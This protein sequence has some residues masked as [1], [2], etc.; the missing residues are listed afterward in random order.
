MKHYKNSPQRCVFIAKPTEGYA[1]KDRDDTAGHFF[2]TGV[3]A[4]G[5]DNVDPDCFL[6]QETKCFG[7]VACSLTRKAAPKEANYFP[8]SLPFQMNDTNVDPMRVYF[9]SI[10]QD[11]GQPPLRGIWKEDLTTIWASKLSNERYAPKEVLAADC[12][13]SSLPSFVH[14]LHYF[15]SVDVNA[16][17]VQ[18]NPEG[19]AIVQRQSEGNPACHT[20]HIFN[21]NHFHWNLSETNK[22]L[23][24]QNITSHIMGAAT[25][26]ASAFFIGLVS[27]VI[28]CTMIIAYHLVSAKAEISNPPCRSWSSAE[29]IAGAKGRPGTMRK[30][31]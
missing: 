10:K 15:Y 5:T 24:I 12:L 25:F 8:G 27:G 30:A 26:D 22:R 19:S 11:P 23:P 29:E 7:S 21:L 31:E 6:L 13:N 16:D 17:T 28:L 4:S 9:D 14:H 18:P 20:T 3:G 1:I 2:K